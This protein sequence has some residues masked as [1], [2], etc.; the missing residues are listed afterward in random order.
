V[1]DLS[2]RSPPPRAPQVRSDKHSTPLERLTDYATPA[3]IVVAFAVNYLDVVT[4]VQVLVQ[5][6]RSGNHALF[7]VS[8]GLMVL[9]GVLNCALEYTLMGGWKGI[10]A[11]Q[12]VRRLDR[13]E[14][15]AAGEG[16]AERDEGRMRLF[17]FRCV[18]NMLQLRMAYE[19]ARALHGYVTERRGVHDGMSQSKAAEGFFEALPQSMVQLFV[20][21]GGVAGLMVVCEGGGGVDFFGADDRSTLVRSLCLS[22]VSTGLS[23]TLLAKQLKLPRKVRHAP[24]APPRPAAAR[25]PACSARP[26][27]GGCAR[28]VH[29]HAHART[30]PRPRS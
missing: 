19:S 24:P 20:L 3:T 21:L 17:G 29:A 10:V 8:G 6:W 16:G 4:D 5:F 25:P 7:G 27:G 12:L 30:A 1:L 15:R 13:E 18:L 14:P 26:L 9:S 11:D 23:V 28:G 2:A 22:F